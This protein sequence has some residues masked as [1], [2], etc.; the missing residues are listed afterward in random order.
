MYV[1]PP[2]PVTVIGASISTSF[3][4]ADSAES[5]DGSQNHINEESIVSG[6]PRSAT[7]MWPCVSTKHCALTGFE[8]GVFIGIFFR[9]GH[10][11]LQLFALHE[12]QYN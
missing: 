1:P 8:I 5:P 7:A 3:S 10:T 11:V 9:L 4:P 2:A 6:T 12:V